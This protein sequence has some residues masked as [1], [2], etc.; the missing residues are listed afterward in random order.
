MNDLIRDNLRENVNLHDTT[1]T[2]NLHYKWKSRKIYNFSKY[3]LPIFLKKY[4]WR[5]L[6][7][8]DDDQSNFAAKIKAL[9]K[10]NKNNLKL[11]IKIIFW[12]NLELLFS[13]RE[14]VLNTFKSR[15]FPIKNLDKI[16]T[17]ESTSE[18]ATEPTKATKAET[19][20]KISLLKL[21]WN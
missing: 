15:L 4:T 10:E 11:I 20:R 18:V 2:D 9:E 16:P 13:A 19:K 14:N 8:A 5:A 17:R 6:K 7:D 12:N 3:S 21:K 1:K